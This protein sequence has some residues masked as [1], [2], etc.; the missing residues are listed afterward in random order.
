MMKYMVYAK[1]YEPEND[2]KIEC[3]DIYE[4]NKYAEACRKQGYK[5]VCTEVESVIS[6]RYGNEKYYQLI[7]DDM[8]IYIAICE[9]GRVRG[10]SENEFIEKEKKVNNTKGAERV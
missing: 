7:V 8:I 10:I 6:F 1:D 2:I 9:N 4:M 3:A 5:E